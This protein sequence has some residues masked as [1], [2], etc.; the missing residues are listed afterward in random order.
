MA[1][2]VRYCNGE[3]VATV[4]TGGIDVLRSVD[5]FKPDIVLMDIMMPRLN[6]LT[7]CHQILSR[8]PEAKIILFSGKYSAEHPTVMASG[9]TAFLAKPVRLSE[10]R[11][12]IDQI[13]TARTALTETQ[14]HGEAPPL[15]SS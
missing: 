14:S 15:A 8:R 10:L 2:Y 7:V 5:R 3:V 11:K 9:A 4:T 13:V 6:G 12:V 1:S